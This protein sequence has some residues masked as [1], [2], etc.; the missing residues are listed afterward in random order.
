MH[1]LFKFNCSFLVYLEAT[2]LIELKMDSFERKC[3]RLAYQREIKVT[4]KI[5]F[6]ALRHSSKNNF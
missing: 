2:Q 3:S 1:F 6:D 4:I 5:G